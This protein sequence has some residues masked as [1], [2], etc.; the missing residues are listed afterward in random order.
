MVLMEGPSILWTI[1]EL[2]ERPSLNRR[3]IIQGQHILSPTH[4]CFEYHEPSL[5]LFLLKIEFCLRL[6]SASDYEPCGYIALT[7]PPQAI[8]G[9]R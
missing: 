8:E 6:R 5:L 3:P 4:S 7:A 1:D 2:K 9:P